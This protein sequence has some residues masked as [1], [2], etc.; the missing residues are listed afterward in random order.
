[1]SKV[2]VCYPLYPFSWLY[3]LGAGIRNKMF[4]WGFLKSQSFNLPIIS[5][6]NLSVGGTG[7]TPHTEYLIRL[8]QPLGKV[9]V[10]SRGYKRCTK[11][12]VLATPHSTMPELGDEP[13]QMKQ[14]FP[15]IMMAVDAN[16]CHGVQEIL[17]TETPL[18]IL[19]DD[20]YQ[21]RYINRGLNILLTDYNRPY[22]KDAILPAGRLRESRKGSSRAD[23]II[24]TKCPEKLSIEQIQN[25]EKQIAPNS[26]Q[27]LYFSRI[28]YASTQ[29]LLHGE[30]NVALSGRNVLLLSG[31]ANPKPLLD[32]VEKSAKKIKHLSF[33]DHHQFTAD[34][35]LQITKELEALGKDAIILTT[36]KDGTRL[37]SMKEL[38]PT[39]KEKTWVLPIKIEILN[40]KTQQFNQTIIDY[41]TK[42]TRNSSL[43]E[44]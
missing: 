36:E 5:I 40:N 22:W 25:I 14:N 19:L 42:N 39:I 43:S 17:K 34:D 11:G 3:G 37:K 23:I 15:D 10:L 20:A 18:T 30:E 7:K 38:P 31:I 26:N 35:T 29:N 6:G 33:P 1:M 28:C 2:S 27:Q 13:Y 16:R 9:A 8:L 41:V 4:D 12:F 44:G 24:V 32:Y 21:H